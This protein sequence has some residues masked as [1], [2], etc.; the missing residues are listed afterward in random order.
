MKHVV[1]ISIGSSRR[2]HKV[3]MDI[4]DEKVIIERIGTDGDIQMAI[5]LI[6]E[7]DGKVD[8]FGMG[9]IDVYLNAGKARYRIKDALPIMEAAKITPMVDGSGLKMSLERQVPGFI[10]DNVEKIQGKSVFIIP[11]IDR[12]GMAE[13]FQNL[14]CDLVLGDLMV[15]LGINIPIKSLKML[16][17]IASV[18]APIACRLPFEMLYPTG[19]EQNKEISKAG[20]ID[21]Y[22]C[23]ADIIAGDFHYI[24]HYMPCGMQGKMVVTNTVTVED[25]EWL[26]R[27]GVRILITSTPNMEGRSF[28]TNVIEAMLVALIGKD[29]NEITAEDYLRVLKEINFKPRVEYFGSENACFAEK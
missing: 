10:N 17:R 5:R 8:A 15:A 12:Y 25:S 24:R 9:G 20:K 26:R 4:N 22:F 3:T 14:G 27:C 2:N 1:S 23:E 21:K 28:G 29:I 6:R 18:I 16:D 19:K 11:G 13:G 7:L